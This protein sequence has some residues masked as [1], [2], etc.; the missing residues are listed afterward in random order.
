MNGRTDRCS[1]KKVWAKTKLKPKFLLLNSDFELKIPATFFFFLHHGEVQVTTAT[2]F[3]LSL[4]GLNSR[5]EDQVRLNAL[6]H[7]GGANK[8]VS[9]SERTNRGK[10]RKRAGEKP[11]VQ[12]CVLYERPRSLAVAWPPFPSFMQSW[13]RG[14]SKL[15][16]QRNIGV[17]SLYL[18]AVVP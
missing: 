14:I 2:A 13:I 10:R 18:L 9:S 6:H 5:L 3:L 17:K 16:F 4:S 8:I 7:R 12:V 15:I 11:F 1:G